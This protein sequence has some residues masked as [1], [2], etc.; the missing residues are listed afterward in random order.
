MNRQV[1]LVALLEVDRLVCYV[2]G[3][4]SKASLPPREKLLRAANKLFYDEGIHTVG[5]DRVIERAGVAKAS[6]YS[7][8]GSKDELIRAYLVGRFD[9]R[10]KRVQEALGRHTT[11]RARILGVFDMLGEMFATPGYRGCAF[12]RASADGSSDKSV[13]G[14]CDDARGWLRS[15]F[16]GLCREA[17][18][19]DPDALGSQLVLLYDGATVGAQMD[20]DPSAAQAAREIASQLLDSARVG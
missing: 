16:V 1:C 19:A 13:K 6:L 2:K 9:M 8:F 15:I 11:P 5:I 17:G 18:V 4:S 12:V 7:A 20:R 3:M 10:K 14:V